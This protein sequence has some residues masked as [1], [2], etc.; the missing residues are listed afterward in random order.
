MPGRVVQNQVKLAAMNIY[1]RDIL[2]LCDILDICGFS[3]STFWRTKKLWDET[4]WVA[5]PK[6]TTSG[7]PRFCAREDIDYILSLVKQRPDY[8]LDELLNLT[9]LNRHISVHFTTIFRELE[10]LGMSRKKLKK[11]A[12]ERNENVRIDFTRRMAQYPPEY[13]GF[14]DETSKNNRTYGRGYGRAPKGRR[15]QMRQDFVRGT[16]LTGTGLLTLDGMVAST[17]VE[18]SMKRVD[19][20]AFLEHEVMPLT[21]PFP[22]P[23]S[24]LVMDNAR[25][26]H[27]E[28]ILAL[29]ER[30]GPCANRVP[31][32]L[33]SRLQSH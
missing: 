28:E 16:R 7:R 27:G 31:S 15:A 22:G 30:F 19:Y 14:L 8:F 24:V 18:G 33:L 26:H 1:E 12:K 17:V 10:R 13:L 23:L 21:T 25:I 6:S 11:V 2:P 32:P 5:K 20:L 4:G 9:K 29:A 3:E